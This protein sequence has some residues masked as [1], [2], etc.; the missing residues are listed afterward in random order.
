MSRIFRSVSMLAGFLCLAGCA[1]LGDGAH[2][3]SKFTLAIEGMPACTI[4]VAENATPAARLASL[5]LQF[6]VLKITGAEIPIRTDADAVAGL[7]ILVGES[8]ATRALGIKTAD[9]AS[10][11]YLIDF[12]P[13]TIIL[14][15]RDWVDTPENR[16]EFGR[17][18]NCGDTL[19]ATRHKIDYWKTV[20]RPERST[21][22]MELPGLYDDQA[23]CYAAYDFI[24]KFLDVR[25]YGAP[26]NAIIIPAASTL[27]VRGKDIRRSPALKY[28]DY[29]FAGGWPFIQGQWGA[30][31]EPEKCLFWRRMKLGGEK[32]G[33]NHTFHRKTVETVF[34]N[35]E[36][37]AQ[38]P[39]KGTQL[40]Y[41]NPK[42]VAQVAQIARDYFDGKANAPEG[43]KAVGNYF[44]LIPDDNSNYC[45]CEKCKAL[46]D[47]GKG[48]ETRQF[49][50]GTI[51]NHFF[52]F[53][54]EVARE[55]R[56][57]HP[58]KYI[59]T[60]AYWNYA[61]PP[62][63]FELEPNVSIAPCLHTCMYAIH[64][65]MREN[66][67]ILYKDWL[68]RTQAPI[69]L[70]NYYHHPME[71]A[72]IDKFKC[73]PNLMPHCSADTMRMFIRDGIRGIFICGQQD[74]LESYIIAKI[75]DDPEQDVDRMMNEF[76]SRYFGSAAKPMNRF[77][78]E[79]ES[80]AT[81]PKNY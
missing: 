32:W 45:R 41:S 21:G 60:L 5:E 3:T 18:M 22:E 71:P 10:Q 43:W 68:R 24:E 67:M 72:L 63:N 34:N 73:F 33:G 11:E 62:T 38:G 39:G 40:C 42:L 31:T 53:V 77:Y 66:D 1:S 78:R 59:A 54:N 75:W 15:G 48:M 49:S 36:Y 50:S 52:S 80:I 55:V 7:R 14:I 12:R 58:D 70:W 76:F 69:Y 37:Q 23:T 20:G 65:E 2:G 9:F 4:V 46:I 81:N 44:A 74:M 6:H 17:P 8:E 35:P 51:S 27:S 25:W 13:G 29:L 79:I 16:A 56:K 26:Q 61:F 30:V 47:S 28:R 64:K 57:T 19:A